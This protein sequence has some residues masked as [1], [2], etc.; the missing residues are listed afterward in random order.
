VLRFEKSNKQGLKPRLNRLVI[1]RQN[2]RQMLLYS[3]LRK[4][5]RED[6]VCGDLPG[7]TLLYRRDCMV[8]FLAR[9]T[10]FPQLTRQQA[11]GK[12]HPY[13]Q[14]TARA[15]YANITLQAMR[16]DLKHSQN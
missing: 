6:Q 4:L 3:K 2:R 7:N 10:G 16:I 12:R 14:V 5:N 8:L 9:G 11:L 13:A 15:I 1:G